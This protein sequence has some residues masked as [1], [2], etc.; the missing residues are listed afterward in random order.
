[1][2]E[3]RLRTLFEGSGTIVSTRLVID[4]QT[5]RSKGFGF[6][7]FETPYAADAAIAELS[8][9]LID[10]RELIV[11]EARPREFSQSS[12]G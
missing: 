7:E 4:Q 8:G 12:R 2:T 10:G 1:M 6:V 3:E 9:C 5:Q 11:N